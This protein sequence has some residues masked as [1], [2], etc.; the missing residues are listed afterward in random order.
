MDVTSFAYQQA[1]SQITAQEQDEAHN[2][3]NVIQGRWFLSHHPLFWDWIN[4]VI[5]LLLG[6]GICVPGFAILAD[7]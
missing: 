6:M 7:V 1:I 3:L 4:V 2:M 5:Y